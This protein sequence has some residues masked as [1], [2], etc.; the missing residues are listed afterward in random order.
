MRKGGSS[1]GGGVREELADDT[2][3][4]VEAEIIGEERAPGDD[5]VDG[6]ESEVDSFLLGRWD[7]DGRRGDVGCG[8]EGEE[9]REE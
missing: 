3:G 9:E 7:L 2:V 4:T 6:F 8:D 5:G 1:G